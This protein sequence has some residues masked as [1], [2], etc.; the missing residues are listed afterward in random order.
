MASE[1]GKAKTAARMK[2]YHAERKKR[3]AS[4]GAMY[5]VRQKIDA[6]AGR[7]R[8]RKKRGAAGRRGSR[9]LQEEIARQ[10]GGRGAVSDRTL[11]SAATGCMVGKPLD[12]AGR[13]SF[14]VRVQYSR[15]MACF[16]D[17]VIWTR[18]NTVYRR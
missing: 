4:E 1:E 17:Y 2:A 11:T 16:D 9:K 7:S 14:G 10:L 6:Q 15:G 5:A 8:G 3:Y 12:E 18:R 13:R